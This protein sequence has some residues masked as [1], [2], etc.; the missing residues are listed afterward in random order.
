MDIGGFEEGE[1]EY[2]EWGAAE[3]ARGRF[4]GSRTTVELSLR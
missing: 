2:V 4:G 1:N 3:S